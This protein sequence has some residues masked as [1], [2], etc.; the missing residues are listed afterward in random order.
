MKKHN[1]EIVKK[2]RAYATPM[3]KFNLIDWLEANLADTD[4]SATAS[5]CV[6]NRGFVAHLVELSDGKGSARR[7]TVPVLSDEFTFD[8]YGIYTTYSMMPPKARY[9]GKNMYI[10]GHKDGYILVSYKTMI[11][12]YHAD[13]NTVYFKQNAFMCS[14]T[15]SRHINEFLTHFVDANAIK[16][17]AK[18]GYGR[19]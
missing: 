1:N 13:R 14:A 18:Q 16:M 4:I 17:Y 2:L 7:F 15:T 19:D 6:D 5:P 3:G 9:K 12:F 8:S 11:C 10:V